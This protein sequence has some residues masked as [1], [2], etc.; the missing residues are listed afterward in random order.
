MTTRTFDTLEA[1][2]ILEASGVESAQAEAIVTVMNRQD[3]ATKADL[4]ALRVGLRAD[5]YHAL[6]VQGMGV[7]IMI[8]SFIAIAGAL[9]LL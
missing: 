6:W 3:L 4:E 8:G 7:V 1:V 2:R 9:K 5:L